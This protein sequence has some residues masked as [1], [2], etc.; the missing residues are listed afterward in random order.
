MKFLL[1]TLVCFAFAGCI[2]ADADNS[3]WQGETVVE[4]TSNASPFEDQQF[5]WNAAG[6]EEVEMPLVGTGK[7]TVTTKSQLG[8]TLDVVFEGDSIECNDNGNLVLVIGGTSTQE[9]DC[10]A[11]TMNSTMF[12]HVYGASSGEILIRYK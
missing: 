12:A 1:V 8:Q 4:K 2:D 9:I 11:S 3:E 6:Y 7:F 5:S 10:E